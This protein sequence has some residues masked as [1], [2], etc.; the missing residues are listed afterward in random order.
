MYNIAPDISRKRFLIEGYFQNMVN[1]KTIAEYFSHITNGLSLKTYGDPIVHTINGMGK[2]AN[3]GYDAFVPLIDSGIYMAVWSNLKFLSLIIY[4]C[5]N[6]DE[7]LA[8][9]L[10]K[11]FFQIT[12]SEHKIF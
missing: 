5:K 11:E 9:K 2:E 1:E 10:T 3:Q 4:T 12:E 7:N 6:F 8:L